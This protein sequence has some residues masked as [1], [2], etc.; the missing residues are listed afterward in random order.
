MDSAS[1]LYILFIALSDCMFFFRSGGLLVTEFN[2]NF[3]RQVFANGTI[4]AL[5]GNGSS[6]P[7]FL[8]DGA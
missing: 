6:T 5:A 7:G 8:G 2:T 4:I 3:V 1:C